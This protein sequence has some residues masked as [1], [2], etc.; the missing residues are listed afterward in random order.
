M[1]KMDQAYPPS[2]NAGQQQNLQQQPYASIRQ[3]RYIAP[4]QSYNQ[5]PRPNAPSTYPILGAI[6]QLMEQMNKMNSRMDKIQDFIKT[7]IPTLT[8]NKKGKQVSFSD[9]LPS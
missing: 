9:Q 2:Y 5:A 8:D 6:S 7:S 4:Q 3:S 1:R